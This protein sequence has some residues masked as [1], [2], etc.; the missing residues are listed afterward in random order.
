MNGRTNMDAQG[1][2]GSECILCFL[3]PHVLFIHID[4]LHIDSL[5]VLCLNCDSERSSQSSSRWKDAFSAPKKRQIAQ[6]VDLVDF[7]RSR[8][9]RMVNNIYF[10]NSSRKRHRKR[11]LNSTTITM[12]SHKMECHILSTLSMRMEGDSHNFE[13]LSLRCSLIQRQS[14]ILTFY[15]M[16]KWYVIIYFSINALHF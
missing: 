14:T 12:G 4:I 1:G 16:P 13:H 9:N 6:C 15:P 5:D 8:R 3:S 11:D 7:R 10:V 2:R